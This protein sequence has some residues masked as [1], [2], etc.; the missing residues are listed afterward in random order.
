MK[1]ETVRGGGAMTAALVFTGTHSIKEY[2]FLV[3][4][5]KLMSR[6]SG[7]TLFQTTRSCTMRKKDYVCVI[8]VVVSNVKIL[9]YY[10]ICGYVVMFPSFQT[11][12]HLVFYLSRIKLCMFY[13][14]I[15][16]M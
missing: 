15:T 9:A 14:S 3:M 2:W 13:I 16:I 1:K 7:S 10:G 4:L 6:A 12:L 8:T 11:T 5:T